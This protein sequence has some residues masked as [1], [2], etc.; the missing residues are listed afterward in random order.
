VSER[1]GV[2]AQFE[3][4]GDLAA[5]CP[6]RLELL[7]AEPARLPVD[8]AQRADHEAVRGDQRH[9]GVEPDAG[10]GPDGGVVGEPDVVPG[11]G[12]H[13]QVLAE[14]GVGA[15]RE[16]TR[17]LDLIRA[18]LRL[19]PLPIGVDQ[20]DVRDRHLADGGRQRHDVV[21]V[22]LRWGVEDTEL[23]ERGNAVGFVEW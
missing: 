22:L 2:P 16:F 7:A 17:A 1:G 11:V 9:P 3:L 20:T 12:H 10:V 5:E 8:D 4:C 18:D 23:I 13:E 19:Q 21:E 15:E 6:Q 14:D